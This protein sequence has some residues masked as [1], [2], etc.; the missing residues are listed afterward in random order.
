MLIR[1]HL[2]AHIDLE[3][4]ASQTGIPEDRIAALADGH[5]DPYTHEIGDIASALA[6]DPVHLFRS[7]PV[8]LAQRSG[9][10]LAQ[11]YQPLLIEFDLHVA[12]Y[13]KDLVQ[14]IP[15][16]I[17]SNNAKGARRRGEGWSRTEGIMVYD[18]LG[19]DPLIQ[20]VEQKMGI[21]VLHWPIP[22]APFGATVRFEGVVGIWVNTSG[23]PRS[24]QRFTL[25]HEVGHLLLGH[26]GDLRVEP[27]EDLSSAARGL[28]KAQA[29]EESHAHHFASGTLGDYETVKQ[30]WDGSATP[31]S[32]ASVA[33][34]VGGSYDATINL[35]IAHFRREQAA[36][37]GARKAHV[38]QAYN[39]IGLRDVYRHF[40]DGRDDRRVPGN[41]PNGE[42]LETR[43]RRA[44][45]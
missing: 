12:V 15:E 34:Q 24:Q 18:H 14:T 27:S 10:L 25:A 1:E 44:L 5:E 22:G 31:E 3:R 37:E 32:I 17:P 26:V 6:V 21:P 30:L 20:A 16:A 42:A 7:S 38:G 35:L 11:G 19:A 28:P 8:V 4:L 33:A 29:T 13:G 2:P 45:P 43:L 23:V 41:L 40:E 39:K 9:A 36:L